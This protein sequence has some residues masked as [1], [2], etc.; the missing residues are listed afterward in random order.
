[1]NG[2]A[3]EGQSSRPVGRE[4]VMAAVLEAATELFADKGPDAVTVRE[5]ADRAGVNHALIHRHY[6]TKQELLRVVLSQAL[7]RMSAVS[8]DASDSRTD[9]VSIVAELRSIEP[10]VR[11]V[12]WAILSGYPID[13]LWP[14]YP[15]IE[16]LQ[17]LLTDERDAGGPTTTEGV[18]PA[19]AVVNAAS[20]VLGWMVFRPL[21]QRAGRLDTVSGYDETAMLNDAVNALLDRAR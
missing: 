5:V 21:L 18:D 19:I 14:E 2:R 16:K 8:Q 1:V 7:A 20:L 4:E 9:V 15:A 10:A 17:S 12:A 13:E 3:A 11:L 6:G